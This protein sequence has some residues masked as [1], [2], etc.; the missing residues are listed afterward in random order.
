MKTGMRLILLTAAVLA[1]ICAA[2]CIGPTQ[3][4]DLPKLL[5][6]LGGSARTPELERAA[7][8]LWELR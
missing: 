1:V 3:L 7:L 2:L 8:V 5:A 4:L 6:L